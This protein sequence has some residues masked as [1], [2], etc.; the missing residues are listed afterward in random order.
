MRSN[1]NHICSARATLTARTASQRGPLPVLR[2][3]ICI[4]RNLSLKMP[5]DPPSPPPYTD[6]QHPRPG[7]R[8]SLFLDISD[9]LLGEDQPARASLDPRF[10]D[11]TRSEYL[12]GSPPLR[13]PR[14]GH[15]YRKCI[16][17]CTRW[18]H[19]ARSAL[20][21]PSTAVQSFFI[22]VEPQNRRPHPPAQRPLRPANPE[23][24][25]AEVR[26]LCK[27]L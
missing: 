7:G 4:A 24:W 2:V 9:S 25:F 14:E 26:C 27:P 19:R 17:V 12:N 13:K 16:E 21:F 15:S 10:R 23:V 3:R 11:H 18:Y 1:N 22:S 6:G 8:V 20:R 5:N